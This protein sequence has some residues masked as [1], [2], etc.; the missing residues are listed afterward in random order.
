[1]RV[2]RVY[3]ACVYV[4]KFG[5][6]AVRSSVPLHIGWIHYTFYPIYRNVK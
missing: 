2:A 6:L 3:S 4:Y 5:M 1:M